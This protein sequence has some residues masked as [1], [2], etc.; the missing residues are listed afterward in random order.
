MFLGLP[1]HGLPEPTPEPAVS[2]FPLVLVGPCKTCKHFNFNDDWDCRPAGDE[3]G[4]CELIWYTGGEKAEI[5]GDVGKLKVQPDFG[6]VLHK[7]K[8]STDGSQS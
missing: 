7:S 4:I 6:C 3:S 8:E 2:T 5:I 1:Y